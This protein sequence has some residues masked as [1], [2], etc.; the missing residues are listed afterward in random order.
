RSG[1]FRL[2]EPQA[3]KYVVVAVLVP[4]SQAM[5]TFQFLNRGTAGT[6]RRSYVEF[7]DKANARLKLS[8]VYVHCD[9]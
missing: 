2:S 5:V 4:L 9:D 1:R 8:A 6:I 3:Q 7:A